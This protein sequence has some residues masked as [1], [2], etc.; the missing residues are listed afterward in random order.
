MEE[1]VTTVKCDAASLGTA[2]H[3]KTFDPTTAESFESLSL[4]G[5]NLNIEETT[6]SDFDDDEDF[7]EKLDPFHMPSTGNVNTFKTESS[8][9]KPHTKVSLTNNSKC[10]N[11]LL[12]PSEIQLSKNSGSPQSLSNSLTNLKSAN[13]TKS[14]TLDGFN[15]LDKTKSHCDLTYTPANFPTESSPTMDAAEKIVTCSSNSS[16]YSQ[17]KSSSSNT[18]FS[19]N[20]EQSSE[21]KVII[22]GKTDKSFMS[23]MKNSF[24][25]LASLLSLSNSRVK[26][27]T[28]KP[29]PPP[30]HTK[31]EVSKVGKKRLCVKPQNL[32]K[33]I[34]TS[35]EPVRKEKVVAEKGKTNEI[36]LSQA[37]KPKKKLNPG[38]QLINHINTFYKEIQPAY[39]NIH[40]KNSNNVAYKLNQNHHKSTP[41]NILPSPPTERKPMWRETRASRLRL[42]RV[43]AP[44][45][46]TLNL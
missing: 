26:K 32:N 44:S 29:V 25:R 30:P 42:N 11:Y 18:F 14:G 3:S 9:R 1:H 15:S 2:A 39:K 13:V 43:K 5:D 19:L 17:S 27:E 37:V 31:P 21:A 46:S 38:P 10:K 35:K 8:E 41:G 34:P 28:L 12:P 33:T 36:K 7:T 22:N 4:S 23:S 24:K 6:I 20:D 16:F 40:Y 45:M